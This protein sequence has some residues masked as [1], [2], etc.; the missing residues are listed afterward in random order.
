M[1]GS[2]L[3]EPALATAS[4]KPS[5]NTTT[6]RFCANRLANWIGSPWV[7]VSMPSGAW[8]KAGATAVGATGVDPALPHAANANPKKAA[9][10]IRLMGPPYATFPACTIRSSRSS[11]KCLANFPPG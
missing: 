3:T 1:R 5:E 6:V 9:Q 2:Q 7:P 10:V 11:K 4:K 8:V